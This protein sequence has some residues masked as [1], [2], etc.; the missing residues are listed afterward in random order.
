MK[1]LH[2][3]GD[4]RDRIASPGGATGPGAVGD[5]DVLKVVAGA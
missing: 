3:V 1:A 4:A 2:V 5:K